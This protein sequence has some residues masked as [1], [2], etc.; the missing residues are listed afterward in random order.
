MH[1]EADPVSVINV[2]LGTELVAWKQVMT[3][4]GEAETKMWQLAVRALRN[5]QETVTI[6]L[7]VH[8]HRHL[9]FPHGWKRFQKW[10]PGSRSRDHLT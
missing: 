2:L 4:V 1:T 5:R 8:V 6:R 10:A 9:G 3:R 7:E